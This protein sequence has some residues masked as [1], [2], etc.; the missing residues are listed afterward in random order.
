MFLS[1]TLE[2][3][4]DISA[5]TIQNTSPLFRV[6]PYWSRLSTFFGFPAYA[7]RHPPG[8]NLA[9]FSKLIDKE[10]F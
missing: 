6:A 9:I 5:A 10:L 3:L 7:I 1:R 4:I 2:E 8:M